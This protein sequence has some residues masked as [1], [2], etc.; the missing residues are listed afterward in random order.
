MLGQ[1]KM[2]PS[3]QAILV[4]PG[5]VHFIFDDHSERKNYLKALVDRI[6][7]ADIVYMEEPDLK[8]SEP[9]STETGERNK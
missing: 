1:N 4:N 3:N 2:N 6:Q 7:K 8:L 9:I 5:D